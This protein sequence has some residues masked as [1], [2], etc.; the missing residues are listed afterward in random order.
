[1]TQKIGARELALREMRTK[2]AKEDQVEASIG[3]AGSKPP[4]PTKD[5]LEAKLPP[6]SGKKPVK[7]K[8]KRRSKK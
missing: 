7:R 5:A 1:M 4:K 6:T 3:E 2:A 8:A